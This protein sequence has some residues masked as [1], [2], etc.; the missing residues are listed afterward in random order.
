MINILGNGKLAR[1]ILAAAVI[2]AAAFWLGTSWA[3]TYY[4]EQGRTALNSGSFGEAKTLL[5]RALFFNSRNAVAHAGL[6][7]AILGQQFP[8]RWPNFPDADFKEAIKHYEKSF[9]LGLKEKNLPLYQQAIE[10]AGQAYWAL[11]QYD[12][13]V[14]K[15]LEKIRVDPMRSFWARFLVAYDYFNRSNKPL[16]T[17]DVLLSTPDL[18][19]DALQENKLVE[20]YTTIAR[21]YYYFEDFENTEK[22]ANLAIENAGP[23]NK[24][25]S[26]QLAHVLRAYSAARSGDFTLAEKEI[27]EADKRAD[28]PGIH[29]CRLAQVSYLG[30]DYSKAIRIA[31]AVKN[32]KSTSLYSICLRTMA[33]SFMAQ[34]NIPEARK[35]MEAYLSLTD[36]LEPKN[37]FIVRDRERFKKELQNL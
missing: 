5:E 7:R 18:A 27:S 8:E 12:K 32:T 13:A 33:D 20:I 25:V 22:Y 35:Y 34:K 28:S 36:A 37:I 15:Y 29:A 9:A 16:E 31:A 21:L 10:S 6:A 11:K 19:S 1:W 4:A 30:G 2:L 3:S 24:T 26:I 14:E 23:E 17:L